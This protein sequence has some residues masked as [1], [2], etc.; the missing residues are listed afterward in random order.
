MQKDKNHNFNYKDSSKDDWL[1]E[2]EKKQS[3]FPTSENQDQQKLAQ[4]QSQIIDNL[5]QEYLSQ[6]IKIKQLEN[7][8]SELEHQNEY[9]N[10]LYNSIENSTF[11]KL[12]KKP[13]LIT[14]KF[15]KIIKEEKSKRKVYE[16]FNSYLYRFFSNENLIEQ[17]NTIF[18]KNITFS[19]VVP[20]YNTNKKYLT[21]MIESVQAQT[22][23]NWQL[24]LCDGSDKK[25]HYVEKIC[26]DYASKDSRITYKK[27]DNNL[28]ISGNNNECLK[29]A[30]G[31]Y[32]SLLDHD[33]IL[34]PSALFETMKAICE[35]DADFI[36]TDECTFNS[37]DLNNIGS[38]H[39]KTDYAFDDLLANNYICHF[40]SFKKALL[41]KTGGFRSECDGSQDY[42]LFLRLTNI[43]KNIVHIP[44]VLYFWRAHPQSTAL[45]VDIK[46]Y[47]FDAG[48]KALQDFLDT[49]KIPAKAEKTKFGPTLY[50][51]KFALT[52]E[53]K[54]SII[55]PSC[56]HSTDLSVCIDSIEKST[57]KN[58][59]VIVV[60]N[61]SKEEE[62][63]EY[64][65]TIKKQYDNV[66]IVYYS[67]K[68]NYSKIN[69]YGEKQCSGEYIVLLN[70]DTK[71]ITT[72]WLEELLSYAQRKDVGAVGA[73]LYYPDDTIQHAGIVLG[74]GG[75]ASEA[76]KQMP[77]GEIGYAANLTYARN[78]S[79][80]TGA[81]IMM[82]KEVWD[83]VNGLDEEF[84]VALNDV[85]LCMR[86][87][88]E[89]FLIVW[90]PFAELYHFESKSRG[91]DDTPEKISI[92][93]HERYM[94]KER[95][96]KE[97]E[98]GD[99][100]YNPNFSMSYVFVPKELTGEK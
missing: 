92:Y 15:K 62:T 75:I 13:R 72:N 70:N 29:L 40:T 60:E 24:C 20:L 35:K 97:L 38:V 51:T 52:G 61:N 44:K 56:D 68:F 27:L 93:E 45:S 94:F 46:D 84:A 74:I 19:I 2:I 42:D 89:G 63:F 50:R 32:I 6:G 77:R 95:W 37:P 79:A 49:L 67:G 10:Y 55:I 43:S 28:G 36:Y 48:I 71:V 76:Y 91:A 98:Q 17:K 11:W 73:M 4:T 12:T 22:Y 53:P 47:V 23:K 30:K 21:E 96:Y 88:K 69:N 39:Y 16:S 3:N 80:V 85:D 66:K 99:P 1:S 58:Y 57:Y 90:T 83:L 7:K 5:K 41:N 54:I 8:I 31:E 86:I 26:R 25:H 18:N 14:D 87:R 33:D 65:E 59:E 81:C 82:R 9:L 78:V 100:Y 34:H 64:Y